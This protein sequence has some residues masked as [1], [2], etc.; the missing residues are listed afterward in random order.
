MQIQSSNRQRSFHHIAHLHVV[1]RSLL[2]CALN[3]LL[4]N[5]KHP[6]NGVLPLSSGDSA[7]DKTGPFHNDQQTVFLVKI[8]A[9]YQGQAKEY[10]DQIC[11]KH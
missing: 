11:G 7:S 8:S 1:T 2:I 6:S 4:S 5:F 3:S 9:C 10:A